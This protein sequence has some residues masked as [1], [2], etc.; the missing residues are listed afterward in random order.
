M[1]PT[2]DLLVVGEAFV[3][4]VPLHRGPLRSA[5]GLEV[6]GGGAPANVAVGASR[7]GAVT[8]FLG[9]VGADEFG[10]L[11]RQRFEHEG[12]DVTGLRMAEGEQTGLCFVTLDPSGERSFLHRGGT[13][14]AL[15]DQQDVQPDRVKP[16]RVI[17][18]S[19]GVMRSTAGAQA[20]Y[21]LLDDWR[22]LITADPGTFPRS[23]GDP[24][25]AR[26]RLLPAL[27]RCHVVKCSSD[28]VLYLTGEVEPGAGARRLVEGGAELAIVT[29]GPR[30]ALWAR[31]EDEG[32][33]PTPDVDVVD[34]TGA[35]DAFMAALLMRLAHDRVRPALL[36]VETLHA[37]LAFACAIGA[38]ACTRRGAVAGVPRLALPRGMPSVP[39]GVPR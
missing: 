10:Y 9:V 31:A 20:I 35:G 36:P 6:H 32:R 19:S 1:D 26:E 30:G 2:L 7:L 27:A 16:A 14:H 17:C 21:R 18:F 33:V 28:E 12:V 5:T 38:A 24:L 13:A 34:T 29:C 15:F 37:H 8:G 11:L 25:V 39:P 3:D 22:G 4:F 23:W